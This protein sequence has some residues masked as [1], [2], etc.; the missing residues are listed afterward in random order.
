MNYQ[1]VSLDTIFSKLIRDA[2]IDI[3]E[4]DVVEWC[5]EALEFTGGVKSYEEA[6]AF[7]E[8]NNHQFDLPTG[9]HAIIQIGRNNRWD[10]YK[11]C[12]PEVIQEELIPEE[13]KINIRRSIALTNPPVDAVWLDAAGT[14]IVAYD[15]AYYRPY[16]DFKANY[17]DWRSCRAYRRFTPI[18]LANSTLFNTLVCEDRDQRAYESCTDE[19]TVILG[20]TVRTSFREGQV[21]LAYL[22][23]VRDIESGYPMVPDNISYKTAITKYVQM[24]IAGREFATGRENAERRLAKY[25]SDWQWYC[26]QAS[27]VDKMPHGVD[28]YQDLLDQRSYL[29]PSRNRY[30]GFFGNLSKPE[31]SRFGSIGYNR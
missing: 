26:Q 15:L 16:Y 29:L 6:V 3:D 10:K 4:G 1:Y 2:S 14:P 23:Q 21:A 18:R 30:F 22:R 24:M 11:E 5:G 12:T 31:P 9:L 25:E 13:E 19:Y 8:V 28:E 27:N 17:F 7:I 20:K